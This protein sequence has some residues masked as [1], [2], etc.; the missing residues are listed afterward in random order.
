MQTAA[1]GTGTQSEERPAA[2][3]QAQVCARPAHFKQANQ[4]PPAAKGRGLGE[5]WQGQQGRSSPWQPKGASRRLRRAALEKNLRGEIPA[6][7]P[8]R[9]DVETEVSL[10]LS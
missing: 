5:C 2:T 9:S 6:L 8:F 3:L 1:A 10:S 4:R 7:P